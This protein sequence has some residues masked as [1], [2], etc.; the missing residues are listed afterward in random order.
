MDVQVSALRIREVMDGA[1]LDRVMA[2]K[3]WRQIKSLIDGV[4]MQNSDVVPQQA[5]QHVPQPEPQC[6]RLAANSS[7]K[8][9]IVMGIYTPAGRVQQLQWIQKRDT[10]IELHCSK[11]QDS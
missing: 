4:A 6:G 9:C 10:G 5:P 11:C 8:A 7:E 3:H 2:S 1:L